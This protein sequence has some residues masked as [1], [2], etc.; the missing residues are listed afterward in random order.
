MLLLFLFVSQV[1]ADP[2]D[3]C[4]DGT[5]MPKK[6]DSFPI[7]YDVCACGP[8]N[9]DY[10][11]DGTTAQQVVTTFCNA[12]TTCTT[13]QKSCTCTPDADHFCYHNKGLA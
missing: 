7:G 1:A 2:T 6:D 13:A 10:K 11:A 3:P 4:D 9:E 12:G 5:M 8:V